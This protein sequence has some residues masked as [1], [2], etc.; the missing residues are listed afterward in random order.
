MARGGGFIDEV[1]D[2][3]DLVGNFLGMGADAATSA[4]DQMAGAKEVANSAMEIYDQSL[5]MCVTE[6]QIVLMEQ[7]GADGF[8]NAGMD[9]LEGGGDVSLVDLTEH[10]EAIGEILEEA[11]IQLG[12]VVEA[13]LENSGVEDEESDD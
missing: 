13:V 8:V 12:E 1:M 3:L 7:I 5:G 9:A 4:L 2:V 11:E 6:G 10:P